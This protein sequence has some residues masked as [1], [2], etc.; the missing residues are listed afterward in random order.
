M[1]N[2]QVK[3]IGLEELKTGLRLAPALM[4][5][6]TSK[7]VQK[8]ILTIQSN[9]MKEAPVNKQTGGGTL[10]QRI[11][12]KMTSILRGEVI[13][14]AKYSAYVEAGTRPH[15]I[16][17]VNK[18]VLANRRTGQFFGKLVQHPGTRANP[19]MMRAIE[20]SKQKM[21]EFFKTA[22]VNVFKTIT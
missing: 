14:N 12:S 15:P 6:E 20:K 9:A 8:T 10:Q 19:F 13:S 5:K 3:L 18:K 11:T 7:A 2:I 16:A 17:I 22:I 21:L 4:I 1:I